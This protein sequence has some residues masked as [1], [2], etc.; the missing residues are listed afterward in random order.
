MSILNVAEN[1]INATQIITLI[2][3]EEETLC[4]IT[5]ETPLYCAEHWIGAIY[6]GCNLYAVVDEKTILL[7]TYDDTDG[8]TGK[9][10][11]ER[12][13]QTI[14]DG[15]KTGIRMLKVPAN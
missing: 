4:H 2:D 15:F 13:I 7:E 11:G 6:Y 9:E 3:Y 5:P 8:I 14:R 10:L 1:I 12:A